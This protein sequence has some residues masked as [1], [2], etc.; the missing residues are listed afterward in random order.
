[1]NTFDLNQ[2][3]VESFLAYLPTVPWFAH[4]GQPIAGPDRKSVV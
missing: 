1:M 4:V 3:T 2:A